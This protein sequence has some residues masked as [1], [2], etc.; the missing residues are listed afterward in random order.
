VR[1]GEEGGERERKGKRER[2][3]GWEG[4][5]EG[6]R[7]RGREG[8][9]GGGRGRASHGRKLISSLASVS[10]PASRILP[11]FSLHPDLLQ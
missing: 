10:A 6:R 9:E 8:G 3:G 5:G 11:C 1:E 2:E 7:E 4:K